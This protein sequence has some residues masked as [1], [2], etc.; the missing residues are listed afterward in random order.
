MIVESKDGAAAD[1][2]CGRNNGEDAAPL[3]RKLRL[4]ISPLHLR[5]R[6]IL[7][8]SPFFDSPSFTE[9]AALQRRHSGAQRGRTN[10]EFKEYTGPL[11]TSH[12]DQYDQLSKL[13]SEA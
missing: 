4:L 10:A 7:F 5:G 12:H 3:V 1:L 8:W 11:E 6:W 2:T 13:E 9:S